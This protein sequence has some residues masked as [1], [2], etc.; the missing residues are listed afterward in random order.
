MRIDDENI[1]DDLDEQDKE[2]LRDI[3]RKSEEIEIPESIKPDN[4]MKK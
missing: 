4:I 3:K 1:F 2:I